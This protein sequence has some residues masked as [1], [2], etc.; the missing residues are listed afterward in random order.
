[1]CEVVKPKSVHGFATPVLTNVKAV[2]VIRIRTSYTTY[3]L[4]QQNGP[5]P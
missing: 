3:A 2:G 5:P 4:R 1:M